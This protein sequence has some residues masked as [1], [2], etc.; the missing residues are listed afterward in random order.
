MIGTE[1]LPCPF[2]GGTAS[3][4]GAAVRC[5]NF[6]C[7]TIMTPRWT[8]DV[9]GSAKGGPDVRFALAKADCTRRWN[10][11]AELAPGIAEAAKVLLDACPNPVFDHLKPVL[12]GEVTE[13]IEYTDEDGEEASYKRSVSWTAMKQIITLALRALSEGRA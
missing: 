3:Y 2:C 4:T 13:T 7:N 9:V 11:R 5:N 10:Q 1:L 6:A 8:K 12:M